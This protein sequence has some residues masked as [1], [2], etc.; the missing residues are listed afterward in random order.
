[1]VVC[2]GGFAGGSGKGSL[3]SK[4][5]PDLSHLPTTNSEASAGDGIN[6]STAVGARVINMDRVQ[7]Y[8]TSVVSR[9][10]PTAKLKI[11]VSEVIRDAGGLLL[12]SLG[13]RFCNELGDSEH[14]TTSMCKNAKAPFFLICNAAAAQ[15]AEWHCE[16]YAKRGL[17]KKFESGS[18]LS[19]AIGVSPAK[20]AATFQA[21]NSC[22]EKGKDNFGKTRFPATPFDTG[23]DVFTP[24]W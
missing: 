11:S 1:M 13:D 21:Y 10:D 15:G 20:L 6:L 17:M 8:P 16:F 18:D 7:V 19:K 12:D 2:T 4:Y 3:L 22:A 9:D 24:A 5:R 14:V 23:H